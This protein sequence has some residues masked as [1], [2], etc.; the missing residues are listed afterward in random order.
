MYNN[1]IDILF[2]GNYMGKLSSVFTSVDQEL[3]DYKLKPEI[4][5]LP[6]WFSG[7]VLRVGPAKFEYGKIKLNHWFDGLA[8]LYSFN[9]NGKDICFSNKYLESEQYIAAKKVG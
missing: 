6:S 7:Q 2:M 8:M 3:L 9:S 1:I 4:S 5:N